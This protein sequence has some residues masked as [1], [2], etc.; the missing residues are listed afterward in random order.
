MEI[1]VIEKTVFEQMMTAF[2]NFTQEIKDLLGSNRGD[3]K[4]LNNKEVCELL[5]ISLRTLQTCRDTGVL[6]Y[7]K[8][9]HK[10]FYRIKD[11]EE[12]IN[13][14]LIKT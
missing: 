12:F 6:P 4:W 8:I 13:K 10:C 1:V 7:S 3:E 9:G 11:V 5:H 2:S 14:Q